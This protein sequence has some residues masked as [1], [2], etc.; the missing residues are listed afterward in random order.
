MSKLPPEF[1][2]APAAG[3]APADAAPRARRTRKASLVAEPPPD[4]REV[5]LRL[6]DD[7]HAALEDARQALV[8]AGETVTI[9]QII[10]RVITEWT[11]RTKLAPTAEPA[12][13]ARDESLIDRIRAFATSP[14]RTWRELGATLRR[15]SG[16]PLR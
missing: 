14:L 4:P 15:L 6:T 10:H 3:S 13:T 12:R 5:L 11:L 9:A 1:V 8:R 16:L 7:E 2:K